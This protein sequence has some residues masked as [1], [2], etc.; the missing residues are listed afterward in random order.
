MTSNLRGE[1]AFKEWVLPRAID[2]ACKAV[3]TQMNGVVKALSTAKSITKLTPEFL[4]AWNLDKN[5][6]EPAN[7]LAPDVVKI[8]YSAINTE[9]GLAKNKKK[10]SHMA[11]YSILGQLASHRSQNCSDFSGPMTLFWW[12]NG[13]SRESL[14]VL[15]NLGLSKCFDSAQTVVDSVAD[16]CIDA[17]RVAAQ[18]P[19]GIMGNWDNV[20]ISTSEFVEQ[21]SGGPAKVQS[22]TYAIIYR[23][24]KPNPL[25][26][27][28]G[29][30]L[31]R[32]DIAPDL[33]FNND[34]CPTLA[35]SIATYGNFCAYIVRVLFRYSKGFD[36]D[37]PDHPAFQPILRR[38]LPDD[39]VTT[40][41][42]TRLSTI[43][44]NSIPGNLAVHEDVFAIRAFDLN[45]FLRAQVFQLGIGLFH[46]C[47]N[48]I[49][50]VLQSHHGHETTEGSLAYFFVILEKA[51]LGGKH[52]DYHSLL[53]ALMQI[54]DGLLLD[55]WRLECG[56]PNLAALAASNPSAEQ[57]LIIADRIM[58]N[59]ATPDRSPKAKNDNARQNTRRLIHD[60][61]H[62]AE[63]TRAISAADFGR[64]EDLLGNLAMIFRGAGSKNYC[65]EILYFKHNLNYVWKG[66]GFECVCTH[67][68]YSL[69]D[70]ELQRTR[71]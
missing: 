55:A 19:D 2:I 71:A 30:I 47:L 34:I 10:N 7:K 25:A 16:Y 11:L 28:L 64:V 33:D 58:S 67:H 9:R 65:T 59:R 40:Q 23:L 63:V 6:V 49:W 31:V 24:H 45:P 15:Q 20:N 21:R 41:F 17:A 69:T 54:L 51:R 4:R 70:V 44:E 56:F 8:L 62:V 32:A 29:P 52:P 18:T 42:P 22:G 57:I 61:L 50:A 13:T 14:E 53:A 36:A 39:Y 38:P 37:Y 26:M 60:L 1:E 68:D 12:K 27:V 43:E 3:S 66:D 5:V 35:Q 46:L 48:L